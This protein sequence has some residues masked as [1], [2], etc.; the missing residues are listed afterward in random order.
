[1]TQEALELTTNR[2]QA[3]G[4]NLSARANSGLRGLA[5]PGSGKIEVK[6]L[7][8]GR[9][10]LRLMESGPEPRSGGWLAAGQ[11]TR[12]TTRH[13]LRGD[14]SFLCRPSGVAVVLRFIRVSA[15]SSARQG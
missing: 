7:V 15:R 1:M 4:Y 6:I 9:S 13:L 2:A 8:G 10:R 3:T 11:K 14:G 12:I 5:G